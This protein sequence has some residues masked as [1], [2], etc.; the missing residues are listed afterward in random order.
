M[1]FSAT[2]RGERLPV[3]QVTSPPTEGKID[4]ARHHP[5][6][7]DRDDR[8]SAR[9]RPKRPTRATDTATATARASS[10]CSSRPTSSPAT[11]SSSSNG[12]ATAAWTVRA[13]Y[14]TGG[15]GG[16][17]APGTES[18]LLASQ[19]SLIYDARHSLLFAVNAGSDSLSVFRVSGERL[20][21]VDVVPS[22]GDFPAS[23]AV[24]RDLANVLNAGNEGRLQGFKIHGH[25]LRPLDGSSRSLGL[26]MPTRRTS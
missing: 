8:G 1:D 13:T 21:L 11:R 4:K 25:R 7:P 18:D 6:C 22:G 12:S 3:V 2:P 26:R 10:S 9:V 19:G 14:P 17:A 20:R 15:R 5:A 24:F 23:I 16:A